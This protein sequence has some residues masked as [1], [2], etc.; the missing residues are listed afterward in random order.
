M[1]KRFGVRMICDFD[2]LGYV[3]VRRSTFTHVF[4]DIWQLIFQNKMLNDALFIA[5]DGLSFFCLER[6]L[7]AL[8]LL[9]LFTISV[10]NHVLFSR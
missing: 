5:V 1:G 8:Y 7:V 10:V 9:C 2:A 3:A 4:T 6:S